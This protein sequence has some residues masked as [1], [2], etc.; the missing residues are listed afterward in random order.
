[1]GKVAAIQMNSSHVIGDNLA[2]AGRLLREA[3]A[4][5]ADIACLP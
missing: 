2:S 1:M 4:A 3:R 5:G